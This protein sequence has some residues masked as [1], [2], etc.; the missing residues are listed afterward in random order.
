[1]QLSLYWKNVHSLK[2]EYV[3]AIIAFS[4]IVKT[5]LLGML[6]MCILNNFNII[7][8]TWNAK[9]EVQCVFIFKR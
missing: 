4:I 2:K 5:M 3:K 9:S 6:K 7:K 1:M 8:C